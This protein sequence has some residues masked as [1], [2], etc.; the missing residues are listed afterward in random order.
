MP[1]RGRVR[2]LAVA[3]LF[4]GLL[5]L[6]AADPP[7]AETFTPVASAPAL[8]T[9][10]MLNLKI[11]HDWIKD[12]DYA[13]AAATVNGLAALTQLYGYQGAEPAWRDRVAALSQALGRLA[14][15]A[16]AKQKANCEKAL[17]EC[18]ALLADMGK[19]P[20]KGA[21]ATDRSFKPVGAVK[22]WMALLDGTHADAKSAKTARE[23]EHLASTIAE[24]VNA[25]Q[26]FRREAP[27]QKGAQAVR[28][29]ALLVA[30]KAR[31]GDVEPAR[32]ALKTVYQRCE[33]CHQVHKK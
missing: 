28:A 1:C 9:A 13:S 15:A 24:G 4:M 16:K 20:P 32:E 5:A 17:M 21:K 14:A 29:E 25:V 6:R 18:D 2:G 27:W 12:G 19:N 7:A 8:H 11:A 31:A 33:A 22:D 26:H 30:D 23:L 3:G 10:L